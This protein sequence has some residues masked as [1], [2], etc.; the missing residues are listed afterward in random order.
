[1]EKA[2]RYA[3]VNLCLRKKS[4]VNSFLISQFPNDQRIIL[5]NRGRY[6]GE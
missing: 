1:V 4:R 2:N 6:K 3:M 5:T